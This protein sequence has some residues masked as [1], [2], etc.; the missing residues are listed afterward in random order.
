MARRRATSVG[1]PSTGVGSSFQSPLWR[2]VPSRVRMAS[3]FDSGTECVTGMYSTS[4]GPTAKRSPGFT[5][6]IGIGSAPGSL[7]S[8]ACRRFAVNAV[9]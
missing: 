4:K 6:V 8:L 3:A 7:A 2:T 9:A 1:G 5:T